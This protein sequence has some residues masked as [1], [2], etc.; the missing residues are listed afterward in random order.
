MSLCEDAALHQRRWL[1]CL[2]SALIWAAPG[3][4]HAADASIA[5]DWVDNTGRCPPPADREREIARLLGPSYTPEAG[6][7]LHVEVSEH[8]SSAFNLALRYR[9][10]AVESARH[11]QF[12]SCKEVQE[13]GILLSAMALHDDASQP[14][15]FAPQHAEDAPREPAAPQAGELAPNNAPRDRSSYWHAVRDSARVELEALLDVQSL[16]KAALGPSLGASLRAYE[17]VRIGIFVRYLPKKS[18][19]SELPPQTHASADLI[20]TGLDARFELTYRSLD[21]GPVVELELGALRAHAKGTTASGGRTMWA[22]VGAGMAG[23]LLVHP[24]IALTSKALLILPLLRPQLALD[25]T[26][27]FYTTAKAGFRLFIGVSCALG[28]TD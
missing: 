8:A 2:L 12:A 14:A 11:V 20:S 25:D 23:A 26:S 17:R 4:G 22:S 16:P 24:R 3:L 13:A 27:A 5:L 18:A 19:T 7:A 10:E 9:D 15:S 21:F 6:A 1:G 28:P